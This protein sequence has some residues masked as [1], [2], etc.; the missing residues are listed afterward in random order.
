MKRVRC[1]TNDNINLIGFLYGSE[2]KNECWNLI[3][4]GVDGNIITNEFI[5][6]M[7]IMLSENN[8][9]L[10]CCH[11]RGSFQIYSSNPLSSTEIGKTIGSAFEKFDD[12]IYDIESWIKYALDNGAKKVNLLAHSH[13]CNKLIYYLSQNKNYY[14][15]IDKL[16]FLSPLDLYTRMNNR[17]DV[18]ELYK[19]A[20]IDESKGEL[21]NFICCGFFYKNI[22]SFYDMMENSNINNFPMMSLT[23]ND[24]SVFNS[25]KKEKYIIYG[26]D[27]TKYTNNFDI[28]KKYL[29]MVKILLLLQMIFFIVLVYTNL[30]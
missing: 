2:N 11:H 8:Q 28:K 5:N 23:N 21:D 24:F 19:K 1:I 3:F 16:I 22:S 26:G 25:I 7:G 10:L 4:P 14:K 30:L 9:K 17:R 12:C 18:E 20:K 29:K 13:G 6:E 27:E 15:Y